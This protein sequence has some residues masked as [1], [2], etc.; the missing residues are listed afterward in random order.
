MD[1]LSEEL[2]NAQAELAN[3]TIEINREADTALEVARIDAD[4]KARVAQIQAVSDQKLQGIEQ[5][6]AQMEQATRSSPEAGA[7]TSRTPVD[8]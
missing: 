3:R 4:A 1:R 6:L 7:K 8:L 5:R 2:R